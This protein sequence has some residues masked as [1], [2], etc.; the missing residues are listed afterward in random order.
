MPAVATPGHEH[1][2]DREHAH[3]HP[4]ERLFE[5]RGTT[6]EDSILALWED[7]VAGRDAECPVCG[8]SMSMIGC[9]RCGSELS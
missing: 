9:T 4:E 8:S 6:L 5:P 1:A 3:E 7:L 2:T